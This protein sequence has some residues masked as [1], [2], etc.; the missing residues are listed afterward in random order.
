MSLLFQEY[1]IGKD[2]TQLLSNALAYVTPEQLEMEITRVCLNFSDLIYVNLTFEMTGVS[3]EV[4]SLSSTY[5][6]PNS[7]GVCSGQ[8]FTFGQRLP[9]KCMKKAQ[10]IDGAFLTL[11]VARERSP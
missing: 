10:I 11:A 9:A 2:N 3:K 6:G 1:K 8:S 4:H 7:M 5:T